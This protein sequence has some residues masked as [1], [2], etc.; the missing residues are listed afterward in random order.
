MNKISINWRI[1]DN[2]QKK[3]IS[4]SNI[5]AIIKAISKC[6][7]PVSLSVNRLLEHPEYESVID[8]II[9]K[10]C[11]IEL[12]IFDRLDSPTKLYESFRNRKILKIIAS[13]DRQDK[14]INKDSFV[15]HLDILHKRGINFEVETKLL[16]DMYELRI[17]RQIF[18]KALSLTPNIRMAM[19]YKDDDRGILENYTD[20]QMKFIDKNFNKGVR[21]IK[22]G[23]R[24]FRSYE[25]YKMGLV[26]TKGMGC[27]NNMYVIDEKGNAWP[28]CSYEIYKNKEK[29]INLIKDNPFFFFMIK[30]ERVIDCPFKACT[31]DSFWADHVKIRVGEKWG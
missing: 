3:A 13:F 26:N 4:I 7:I 6:T 17:A 20:Q 19:A 31:F 22:L 1:I 2:D 12:R 18:A 27:V 21:N 14:K 11:P 24:Y 9:E 23:R 28:C 15:K 30:K 25:I 29:P 16:A 10:C 8:S 5:N